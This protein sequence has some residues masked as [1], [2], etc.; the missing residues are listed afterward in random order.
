MKGTP[1]N[2]CVP[3]AEDISECFWKQISHMQRNMPYT[4]RRMI[5]TQ[6]KGDNSKCGLMGAEGVQPTTDLK[7]VFY[8]A[9]GPKVHT[10]AVHSCVVSEQVYQ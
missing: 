2:N 7:V 8:F 4:V 3:A 10:Q 9:P 5:T 1:H 6:G